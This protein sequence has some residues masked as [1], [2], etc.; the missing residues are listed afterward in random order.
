[1]NAMHLW[2]LA[3][4]PGEPETIFAGPQP[5]AVFRSRDGGRRWEKLA[6]ALA[7]ECTAVVIPRVTALVVD[8]E[9]HRTIWAGIEVDGV[10][11]SLDGGETWTTIAGG[12]GDPDIHGIAV[13]RGQPKAVLATTPREVF[14]STDAGESWQRLEVMQQFPHSYTRAIAVKEDDPHVIFVGHGKTA[15]PTIG[16][17]QRSQ[18]GGQTSGTPPLPREPHSQISCLATHPSDP[19]LVLA[20][21]LYGQLF[22]SHDAGD[23]WRKVRQEVSQGPALA[24]V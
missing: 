6:M 18:D 23:A 9:D 14:A 8:P 5:S 19:N 4:D 12:L 21:T 3:I 11:R 7:E 16:S 15:S 24:W 20:S 1:M 22:M 17:V 10:R 13:R 2:A